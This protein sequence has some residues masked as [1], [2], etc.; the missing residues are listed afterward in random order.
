MPKKTTDDMTKETM[1]NCPD[2]ETLVRY[3]DNEL[4]DREKRA[5]KQHLETCSTCQGRVASLK[6][7][8]ANLS[9]A[10]KSMDVEETASCLSDEDISAY[11]DETVTEEEKTD[12]EEHL[13]ECLWCIRRLI[14]TKEDILLYEKGEF[15][16]PDEALVE[17][18]KNLSPGGKVFS[19]AAK[20]T[21]ADGMMECK[22]C[23]AKNP[24]QSTFCR[25]CGEKLDMLSIAC[26]HCGKDVVEGSKF[27]NFCGKKLVLDEIS[28]NKALMNAVSQWLQ[29]LPAPIR[30]NKWLIGAIATFAGSFAFSAVFLQFLVASGF[31]AGVWIFDKNRREMLRDIYKLWKEEGKP[32][33]FEQLS[34]HARAKVLEL[35]KKIT[36]K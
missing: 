15:E 30:E 17:K 11:A 5:M 24:P 8:Q 16:E 2:F 28:K 26:I 3:T 36:G 34:Q 9:F 35:K 13:A 21:E 18:M 14:E 23:S 25:G 20:K 32:P 12:Y 10:F 31:F 33:S 7:L 6:E 4:T 29:K 22:L 19:V 27:C 1:K